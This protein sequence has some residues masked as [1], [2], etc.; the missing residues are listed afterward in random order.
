MFFLWVEWKDFSIQAITEAVLKLLE[1]E[2][3]K[4]N[5]G[6]AAL[7]FKLPCIV[8]ELQL[9]APKGKRGL[10]KEGATGMP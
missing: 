8:R 6:C 7:T 3:G 9:P 4:N 10:E 1:Q 2:K 5:G